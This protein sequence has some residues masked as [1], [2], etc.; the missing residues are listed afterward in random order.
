MGGAGLKIHDSLS[1]YEENH[2]VRTK[3]FS[4]HNK[5]EFTIM[6]ANRAFL[7]TPEVELH[8]EHRVFPLSRDRGVRHREARETAESESI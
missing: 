2:L 8:G 1:G 6:C 3:T 7:R 4:T 5:P